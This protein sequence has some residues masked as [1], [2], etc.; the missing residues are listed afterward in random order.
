MTR[1]RIS[2]A[3]ILLLLTALSAYP[4]QG[5]G[6]GTGQGIAQ[7]SPASGGRQA[8]AGPPI[9]AAAVSEQFHTISLGGRIEPKNR[10]VHQ[11]DSAGYVQNIKVQV[12]DIVKAGQN[13]LSVTRK[14]DVLNLYKPTVLTARISGRVS[15]I[16]VQVED[17]V[18][19]GEEAVVIIGTD[20]YSLSTYVSDK[21]AFRIN[22]GQQVSA[23]TPGGTV[24][25][26][27]LVSRSPEPDYA[28][29]LFHLNFSFPNSQ[30]VHI[31]EFILVDLPIDRTRG[32]FIRRDQAVRRYGKY[33]IWIVT[34]DMTLTAREVTLGTVFG[35]LILVDEGLEPGETYL[36]RLSGREKEGDSV[37]PPG[38]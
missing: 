32:V 6:S 34:D 1:F 4:Q 35:D 19:A 9:A 18:K 12:G 22:P 36:T 11:I 2:A 26:G 8:P 21:D 37:T 23:R 7:T 15:D 24:I 38:E 10:V 17:E 30:Q 31:G 13:L 16:K 25:R 14:D 20:G 33:F 27:T 3:I 28:T 5:S 29:G